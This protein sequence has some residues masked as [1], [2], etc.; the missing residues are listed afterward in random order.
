VP[1]DNSGKTQPARRKW[2]IVEAWDDDRQINRR[3]VGDAIKALVVVSC[4]TA[5]GYAAHFAP[6]ATPERMRLFDA[7]HFYS[8][9]CLSAYFTILLIVEVTVAFMRGLQKP[10]K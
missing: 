7:Y 3:I 10:E 2:L 9:F 1:S 4:A 5:V 6:G 8:I